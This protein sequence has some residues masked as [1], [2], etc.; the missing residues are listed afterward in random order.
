MS[1]MEQVS[2]RHVAWLLTRPGWGTAHAFDDWTSSPYGPMLSVF[3]LCGER[4]NDGSRIEANLREA[5]LCMRCVRYVE[6]R[7]RRA[8]S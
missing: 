6:I 4:R 1:E 2:V 5:R 7:E 8:A 3:S